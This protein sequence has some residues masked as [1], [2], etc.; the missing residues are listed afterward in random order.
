MTGPAPGGRSDDASPAR[1]R[2]EEAARLLTG[3]SVL[4]RQMLVAVLASPLV[5]AGTIWLALGTHRPL[6]LVGV[7]FALAAFVDGLRTIARHSRRADHGDRRL[8]LHLQR[9]PHRS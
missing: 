4:D 6:L 1:G 7:P 9:Y 5:A 2:T 3:L 8:A